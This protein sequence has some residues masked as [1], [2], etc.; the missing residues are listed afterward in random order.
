MSET[1]PTI[2]GK[3]RTCRSVKFA[4][5][6]F[7]SNFEIKIAQF[8]LSTV[9]SQHVITGYILF[10]KMGPSRSEWKL[11]FEIEHKCIVGY[12][13]IVTTFV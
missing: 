9:A 13:N 1:K 5:R 4:G 12:N 8:A 7:L 3:K 2:T 10:K 11:L 6:I